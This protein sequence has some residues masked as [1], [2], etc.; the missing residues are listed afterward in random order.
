ML[1][2][3][4][5]LKT[6]AL[7]GVAS[8][9]AHTAA[10]A[11]DGAGVVKH[12]DGDP[13]DAALVREGVSKPIRVLQTVCVGDRLQARNAV[14]LISLYGRGSAWVRPGAPYVVQPV[15]G[16]A[17]YAGNAFR[18]F[19]EKTMPDI[20]R[21]RAEARLKGSPE[22]FGFA[23][24]GLS[25]GAQ[26]VNLGR[27]T[28]VLRVTGGQGPYEAK[29]TD[30]A[31][32]SWTTDATSTE[33]H[34]KDV[35]LSPGPVAIEAKDALGHKLAGSFKANPKPAPYPADYQD[36]DDFEV[37]AAGEAIDLARAAPKVRSLEAEQ[38]LNAAPASG[39][40]R[41]AIFDL[42]ESY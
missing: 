27:P 5:L 10:M 28:F 38:Q 35:A 15:V 33:L 14:I 31:G 17:S 30:S 6:A 18:S 24:D 29:M 41:K 7:A 23:L 8:L 19:D 42:I 25:D 22:P 1:K 37:R 36:L 3:I 39:L 32:K 2:F 34:F 9:A 40:D 21:M 20:Q 16:Q 26:E 4:S 12:I 13:S 11:C